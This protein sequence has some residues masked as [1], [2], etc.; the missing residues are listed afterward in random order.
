MSLHSTCLISN[1]TTASAFGRQS[2]DQP[3]AAI[4]RRG[5]WKKMVTAVSS[6]RRLVSRVNWK[7][8]LLETVSNAKSK[9]KYDRLVECKI[10]SAS[11]CSYHSERIDQPFEVKPIA[12]KKSIWNNFY[13]LRSR[14][15]HLKWIYLLGRQYE[16]LRCWQVIFIKMRVKDKGDTFLLLCF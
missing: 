3:I 13:C 4:Q 15:E 11:F 5:T 10:D 2:C 16:A 9:S 14:I 6:G 7:S 1:V 8:H 12:F